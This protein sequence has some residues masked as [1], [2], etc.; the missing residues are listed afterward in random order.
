MLNVQRVYS[1]TIQHLSAGLRC[2]KTLTFLVHRA[3]G[4]EKH[5]VLPLS[6]A[7]EKTTGGIFTAFI[8]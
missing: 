1:R 6:Q 4:G 3:T 2:V 8:Y 5:F 7:R